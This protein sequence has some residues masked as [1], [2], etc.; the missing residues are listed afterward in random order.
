MVDVVVI[1]GGAMGSASAYW[2]KE[3]NKNINV[4]VIEKD[5]TVKKSYFFQIKFT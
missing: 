3:R 2:L 4:A 5:P 1:G